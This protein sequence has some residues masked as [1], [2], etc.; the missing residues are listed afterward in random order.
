[1]ANLKVKKA[2]VVMVH[3]AN[4]NVVNDAKAGGICSDLYNGR[5]TDLAIECAAGNG[6][7]KETLLAH[8]AVLFPVAKRLRDR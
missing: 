7:A 6:G 1:M 4:A 2:G 5:Y 3:L 8:A